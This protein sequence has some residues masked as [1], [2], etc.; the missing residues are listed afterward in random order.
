VVVEEN[1]L[2]A[3]QT[4]SLVSLFHHKINPWKWVMGINHMVALCIVAIGAG[5]GMVMV[6]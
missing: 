1:V 4:Q 6:S 2:P 3:A 5:E